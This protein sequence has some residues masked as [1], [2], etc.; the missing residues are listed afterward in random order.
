MVRSSCLPLIFALPFSLRG[1]SEEGKN[2][3]L[4][5]PSLLFAIS[6]T[7]II[8]AIKLLPRLAP[9]LL[10]GWISSPIV[11]R[12][13]SE[14]G[15][16][17]L[18]LFPSLLFVSPLLPRALIAAAIIPLPRF[19]RLI[20]TMEGVLLTM[21]LR[22]LY[23]CELFVSSLLHCTLGTAA[24][25]AGI[26]LLPCLMLT[27]PS[28]FFWLLVV[29]LSWLGSQ[30]LDLLLPGLIAE[31]IAARSSSIRPFKLPFSESTGDPLGWGGAS[32][33]VLHLEHFW[34]PP[35]G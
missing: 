29:S 20:P 21:A 10:L 12:G 24:N 22:L 33:V 32:G 16:G 13:V 14:E 25:T 6:R 11:I 17:S 23:F 4:L 5:L 2:S 35:G 26:T 3:L 19:A 1:V 18:L 34:S 15:K 30:S 28:S 7:L 27:P 8:A 9:L 31:L